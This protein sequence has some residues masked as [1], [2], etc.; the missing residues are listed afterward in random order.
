MRFKY[1][2]KTL[3]N[4]IPYGL[5]AALLWACASESTTWTS[6][7]F[8]NTTAHY[9]GYYYALEEITKIEKT[10]HH[11]HRDD[12]NEILRLF[13]KL[14]SVK[15]KSYDKEI[16]EVVKMASLSI[17]RHP[18]SKWVDDAY[19]LVGK[20]RLYSFD[21]GNAIQT[22]KY[23]NNPKVTKNAHTRHQALIHLARTFTEHKEYNNAEAVFDFL[24]KEN[25]NKTNLKNFLLEKAYYY[26]V[27]ND[28][29]K[30]I[31]NL[32]QAAPLLTKKDKP[33]R[34]YF[35][36]GQVY[37]KLGFEAEAY[38]YYR[39]CIAT[40][41]E[42]EVD[43]YARLYMAQVAEIS[44]SRNVAAAR[45]SFRKLLK[46]SKNKEFKDKIYY[47]MGVF[48]EKQN[49]INEAITN[50]NLAVRKSNNSLIKGDAYLKLGEIYYDTLK[51]YELAQAYYD[52]AVNTVSTQRPDYASIKARQQVLNDF[53]KHLKTIT[54]QDSLLRLAQMDTA[55]LRN[56][57]KSSVEAKPSVA[58]TKSKKKKTERI[59]ITQASTVADNRNQAQ[60]ADWYFGNPSAVGLGQVEFARIWGKI[61]LEDN[62][63][64]SV[65]AVPQSERPTPIVAG[66]PQHEKQPVAEVKKDPVQEEFD[67]LLKQL[68]TTDDKKKEA[69]KK[70]EEAYFALGDIYYFKLQE[71]NNAIGMYEKL[72][73]RFPKSDHEPEVLYKLYLVF[74]ENDTPRA[75]G[76]AS[77]LIADYPETDFAKI[78]INPTYLQEARLA[79]EKQKVLYKEA[80]EHYLNGRYKASARLVTDALALDNTPFNQQL[81]LL[82]ILITGKTETIAQYQYQLE[83]FIKTY[84]AS[85]TTTYAQNL[86]T[87]SR[88]FELYK[89]KEKATKYLRSFEE[90]HYFIVVYPT[91]ERME[92]TVVQSLNSFNNSYFKELNLKISNLILNE[93]STLTMVSDLPRL[94]SALEYFKTFSEKLN[95]LTGLKSYKFNSFVITKDNFNIFYRTKDL[96]EYLRFFEK[97]YPTENP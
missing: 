36:I 39:Q 76:Y 84:P 92:N 62:W 1:T 70:I 55:S 43:F 81:E 80:Y 91:A 3:R 44:K 37:Q 18:N 12:Y 64:R 90:P 71:K 60:A 28:L 19:I 30:M 49:N 5:L 88:N 66:A 83:Q 77:R 52:S 53:V 27:R 61:P 74:K 9:N 2:L 67:N 78:I 25:L 29:D 40:H 22:F 26:Q 57:I 95:T 93:T 11:N 68:P 42:Y 13:P 96:D 38:N 8:H 87:A 79:M 59:N 86:L 20:A 32:S 17:Q 85:E 97:N 82:R 94:S 51:K 41:P 65:R 16:Q 63:R 14:D 24:Q 34:I 4:T 21:W 48:E 31:R 89:E 75:E 10:I 6:K 50:Y 7:A 47:E 72:L 69:L 56:L 15:A 73:S 23:V 35:I 45:K 54:W 58:V 33:G 46:D